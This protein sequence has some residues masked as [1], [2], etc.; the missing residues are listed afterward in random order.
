MKD[1]DLTRCG[2]IACLLDGHEGTPAE[3][4]HCRIAGGKRDL[5][6]KI[7]LCPAHHRGV[8]SAPGVVSIHGNKTRFR[9]SYGSEASLFE[10][11]E[12]RV[13]VIK[14]NTVGGKL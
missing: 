7:P 12:G 6:I 4:H 9:E 5:A 1:D 13:A 3:I 8:G 14:K 2:C 11:V 10:L